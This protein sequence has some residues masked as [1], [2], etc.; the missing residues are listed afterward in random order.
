[1]NLRAANLNQTG[2]QWS[3]LVKDILD[4]VDYLQVSGLASPFISPIDLF[5]RRIHRSVNA[6]KTDLVQLERS[7]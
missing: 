4:V 5:Y 6:C 3:L 2:Q 1:M 7:C